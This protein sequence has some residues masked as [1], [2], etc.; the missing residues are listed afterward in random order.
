MR[1]RQTGITLIGFLL[2]AAMVGLLGFAGLKLAPI[3]AE[4]MKIRQILEDVKG[5][6]DGANPTP[7]SIRRA[8]DK[9]LN[10]E[11]VSGLDARDFQIEKSSGG[12][13]VIAAYEDRAPFV[14]NVVLLVTF[15]DEVEIKQ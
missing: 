7:Q 5:E 15:D 11:M 9:R 4:N 14:A 2:L 8:I 6:L 12:F 13:R 3:Y 10:V 1:S